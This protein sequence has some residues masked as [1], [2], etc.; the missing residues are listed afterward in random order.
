MRLFLVGGSGRTGRLLLPLALAAGH[1]VTALAR[2]PTSIS[3]AHERL[4][5]L[6]GDV[7]APETLAGHLAGHDA[8]I[9]I[10]SPPSLRGLVDTF[11]VGATTLCRT[12]QREA[13]RRLLFVTSGAV[14]DDPELVWL[15]RFVVKPLLMRR[16]YADA[17]RAEEIVR[18]SAL[19]W[20]LVR[21][22]RLTDGPPTGTYRVSPRGLP[23]GG[24]V[25]ARADLAQF[26]LTE[27]EKP[28]YLH[29]TP[30]LA[31]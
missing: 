16:L 9:G 19:D 5:V 21:P 31:V 4:R 8:V 23:P 1:T 28:Q 14:E 11:T 29:G 12:M 6:R 13:V 22:A 15:F 3:L 27:V 10:L 7:G 24:A 25:L 17:S 18:S 20:T 30:T 26:L 2:Q